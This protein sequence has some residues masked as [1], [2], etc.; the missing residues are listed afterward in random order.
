MRPASELLHHRAPATVLSECVRADGTMFPWAVRSGNL[1]YIG[2]IP[3][4]YMSEGDRY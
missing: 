1:T 4:A 2:E 3:F